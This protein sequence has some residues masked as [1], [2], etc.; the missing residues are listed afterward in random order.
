MLR[1]LNM[2]LLNAMVKGS[3]VRTFQS[4]ILPT[5]TIAAFDISGDR[6]GEEISVAEHGLLAQVSGEECLRIGESGECSSKRVAGE[7]EQRT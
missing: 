4:S 1:S 3:Y 6:R 2:P 5:R 7:P